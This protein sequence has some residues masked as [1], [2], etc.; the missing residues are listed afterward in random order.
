MTV[1]LVG[2]LKGWAQLGM[3]R[4]EPT[5]DPPGC[6]SQ[7]SPTSPLVAQGSKSKYSSEQDEA[8]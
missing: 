5:S 6:Q 1:V 2:L 4:T 8:A 7:G 3:S